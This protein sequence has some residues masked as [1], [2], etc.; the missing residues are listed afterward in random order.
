MTPY[1]TEDMMAL[2]MALENRITIL[3]AELSKK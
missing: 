2:L 1:P 3:E